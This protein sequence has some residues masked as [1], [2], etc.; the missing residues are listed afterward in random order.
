MTCGTWLDVPEGMSAAALDFAG[1]LPGEAPLPV[2]VSCELD[3]HEHDEHAARLRELFDGAAVWVTCE[4]DV[5]KVQSIA[6]C[7]SFRLSHGGIPLSDALCWLP[8]AHR[9]SHTWERCA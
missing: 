4:G 6:Y 9:G 7:E 8:D 2:S 5:I 1:G 3:K